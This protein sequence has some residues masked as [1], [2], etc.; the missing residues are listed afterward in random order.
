MMCAIHAGRRG[1]RVALLEH[2]PRI[3][4]KILISGAGAATSPT[5]TPMQ[6][7]TCLPIPISASRP[8]RVSRRPTSSGW[9]ARTASPITKRSSDSFSARLGAAN[10]RHAAGGMRKA[11]SEFHVGARVNAVRRTDGFV[12]ETN[13][14]AYACRSLVVATG[15]CHTP[16]P[17][18]AIWVIGSRANSGLALWTLPRRWSRS[19]SMAQIVRQLKGWPASQPTHSSAA[20]E[21]RSVRMSSS[22]TPD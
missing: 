18:P 20:T 14:D 3:G 22:P 19:S 13:L 17:G 6:A 2:A 21:S 10:R 5:Y 11:G 1:R 16:R 12:V 15:D 8:W 7:P 9:S 4:K